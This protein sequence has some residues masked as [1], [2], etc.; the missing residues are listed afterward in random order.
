MVTSVLYDQ[1]RAL[2]KDFHR[3]VSCSGEFHGNIRE[4]RH[5]HQMLSQSVQNA[6]NFMMISNVAG[7]C[8]N[9]LNLI[10][11]PYSSI[12]FVDE[13]MEP[14]ALYTLMHV[15][16]L[17]T[18]LSGLLLT[19]SEGIVINHAVC[20]AYCGFPTFITVTL[21]RLLKMLLLKLK[22]T[23]LCNLCIYFVCNVV[24][25][26]RL[27]SIKRS[28]STAEIRLCLGLA[29]FLSNSRS[30]NIYTNRKPLCDFLLMYKTNS[31]LIYRTVSKLSCSVPY[32]MSYWIPKGNCPKPQETAGSQL[33]PHY[34]HGHGVILHMGI[35]SEPMALWL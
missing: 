1:F 12:F 9:I 23:V 13:T 4:F 34:T 27:T 35:P 22:I 10:V 3:A 28:S 8:C 25:L 21:A 33:V 29:S 16:L 18:I 11:I 30:P 14:N 19:T 17:A 2:N 26:Q 6:D 7:F 24:H 20:V 15:V 31:H 32:K 5:R